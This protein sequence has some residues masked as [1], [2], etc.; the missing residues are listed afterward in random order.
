MQELVSRIKKERIQQKVTMEEL[1]LKSGVSQKH[2]SNIENGKAVPTV[3][4][5][6]KLTQVLGFD[7][8]LHLK[9]HKAAR[10]KKPKHGDG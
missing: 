1:S 3:E 9:V 8:A 7:I 10:E 2:I 5:L 6:E 4:T